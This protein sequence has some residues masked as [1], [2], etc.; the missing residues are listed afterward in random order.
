MQYILTKECMIL[1][2]DIINQRLNIALVIAS[3]TSCN[4]ETNKECIIALF[5]PNAPKFGLIML[6][7]TF[8]MSSHVILSNWIEPTA[9]YVETNK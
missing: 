4:F 7:F 6:L 8:D 3:I 5:P 1:L 9:T 2:H